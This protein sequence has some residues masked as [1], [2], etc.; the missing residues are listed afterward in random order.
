MTDNLVRIE[1]QFISDVFWYLPEREFDVFMHLA[2]KLEPM[3]ENEKDVKKQFVKKQFHREETPF[4][5]IIDVIQKSEK[6][7]GSIYK[8]A[9]EIIEKLNQRFVT[10]P[11]WF[12]IEDLETGKKIQIKGNINWFDQ[13]YLVRD[14]E[15]KEVFVRHKFSDELRYVLLQVRRWVTM[16]KQEISVL[17]GGHT[18]HL[19]II[20]KKERFLKKLGN[21][22]EYKLEIREL[23]NLLGIGN[24]YSRFN[25]FRNRILE[26]CRK[27]IE[28]SSLSK[29]VFSY[30]TIREGR[31]IKYIKFKI[32]DAKKPNIKLQ[33]LDYVPS[34]EDIAKLSWAKYNAYEKLVKFGVKEG[35]AV[36]QIIA[37]VKGAEMEGFEDLFIKGA[38]EHF[39][40]WANQQ[41]TR[42]QSAATFVN[43]WTKQKVFD[44]KNDVFFKIA[45]IVNAEKKTME[46]VRIDN[47]RMAK[48]MT[49]EE[50][51]AWYKSNNENND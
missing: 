26:P 38:L 6:K 39:K 37:K 34:K 7:S 16:S 46:Q 3:V 31:Q 17:S 43:W 41:S 28:A 19:Y 45:E 30:E 2:S 11:D 40:K 32:F 4:S 44:I 42:E 29:I 21:Y 25:D 47:R 48:N 14:E 50:F 9:E 24:K 12:N 1:N 36:K 13:I 33:N 27:K 8:E 18:K 22:A 49:M 5:E 35:I 15:E 20:L 51:K 23:K 10:F